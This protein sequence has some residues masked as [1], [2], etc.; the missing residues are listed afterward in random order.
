MAMVMDSAGSM[1]GEKSGLEVCISDL[2]PHLL[3][4][5]RDSCHQIHNI[6]KGFTFYFVGFFERLLRNF[7]TDFRYSTDSLESLKYLS[8]HLYVTF[9]KPS[10]YIAAKWLS[11]LDNALSLSYMM[12][13]YIIY[14]NSVQMGF[15]QLQ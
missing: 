7:C 13:A 3:D 4:I 5:D 9:Q 8:F 6:V 2:A 12:N 15:A 1:H 14:Y 11:I 10:N